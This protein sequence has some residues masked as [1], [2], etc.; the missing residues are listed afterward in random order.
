[1]VALIVFAVTPAMA[2]VSGK[3]SGTVVDVTSDEPII[4]ATVRVLGTS[5]VTKTDEDGEY[6][7]INV[8]GGKYD[9]TVSYLGYESTTKKSVRVLVDLTTPVDF[10][11]SNSTVELDQDLVV[12][13]EEPVIRKDLTESKVIFTADRLKTLPNIITVQSVL[14]NYPGVVV[15]RNKELHVR[16]GR[17]GQVAYYFDG[18]SIQDPF[19]SNSGIRVIPSAL[20]ELS[21]TSGGYT[22]EYGEALSGVVSAVTREGSSEYHGGLTLYQGFT[23][24][25]DVTSGDWT[26]LSKSGDGSGVFNVSGPL[27]GFDPTR[28]TFFASG[29]LLNRGSSLPHNEARAKTGLLKIAIQPAPNLKLKSNLTYHRSEGDLYDHRDVNGISYD[30]NLD[31]LTSYRR[32][33]YLIGFSGDLSVSNRSIISASY[34]AFKT[35]TKESPDHLM[36]L[37]WSQ[38]PGYSEDAEGNYNGTIQDENYLGD[39]DYTSERQMTGFTEGADFDPTYSYR[40]TVY[41]AFNAS[42]LSQLNKDHQFKA[43]VQLRK[44]SIEEDSRQFFNVNPYGE[45]YESKPT[46]ASLFVQDK[47]EY[48]NFVIN[49]G[50]RYDYHNS[51][52]SYNVTP[53]DSVALY[54]VADAQS[55]LAP[56]IGVSFPISEKSVM[57]FNYGI[58]YQPPQFSYLY[59]NVQGDITSGLPLLGNPDLEP[60]RTSSYELGLDHLIGDNLRLDATAY[61]KDINDLITTRA[62]FEVAG[63]AVTRFTN[64]DYGSVKGIDLQLEKLPGDG[65]ISGSIAYSYMIASGNGSTALEPY[66]TYINDQED[67]LAPVTEYPLDF[68]QRHTVTAVLSFKAD[69]K[70]KG[71]LFGFNLPNMWGFTAV[72]HYGS[73][74]P[75]TPID[76]NGNRLGE[77]NEG[78]LPSNYTVDMRLN[79]DFK[80]AGKYLLTLFVEADN[81]FNRLNTINVYARTGQADNDGNVVGAGLTLNQDE[82]NYYDRLYDHDPQNYSPPRTVRIGMDLNF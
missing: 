26:S 31:G 77:R 7:I 41:H 16:G 33:A 59:T 2:G 5:I 35:N 54:K 75:Y 8:P 53:R 45:T 73:G 9:L 79:K 11:L 78:R 32:H 22:A 72:G 52:I 40:S 24:P 42:I 62:L 10:E 15:D 28:Y 39:L 60:E 68:D 38:W 49:L 82:L 71:S 69:A 1:M 57:H 4:G 37:H 51:D 20:E 70:W 47:M 56:R 63:E 81:V 29:E 76:V 74:L 30:L 27:P 55:S 64:A 23:H 58:Y 25:Y 18:F 65:P 48:E 34:N 61:Y 80:V 12:Y 46:Y 36:N 50:L 44:Y 13:A 19:V 14:T 66:Y 67:T 43:G 6:F 3:I 21:L 17:S